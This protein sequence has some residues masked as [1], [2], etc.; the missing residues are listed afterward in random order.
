MNLSHA[1]MGSW[2]RNGGWKFPENSIIRRSLENVF[3]KV[4]SGGKGLFG[5]LRVFGY[6]QIS[7]RFHYNSLVRKGTD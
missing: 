1:Q 3:K 5:T 2:K 7:G 4:I 6:Q